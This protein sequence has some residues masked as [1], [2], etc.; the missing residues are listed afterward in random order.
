MDGETFLK[1]L[2]DHRIPWNDLAQAIA[3]IDGDDRVDALTEALEVLASQTMAEG[4]FRAL[5]QLPPLVLPGGVRG[6]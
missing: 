3:D 1:R 5:A 6:D 2:K 4:T